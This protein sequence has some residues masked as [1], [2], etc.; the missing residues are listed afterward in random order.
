MDGYTELQ[1]RKFLSSEKYIKLG[2]TR[3]KED[4]MRYY[5]GY[6]TKGKSK[7]NFEVKAKSKKNAYA[8]LKEDNPGWRIVITTSYKHQVKG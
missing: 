8:N 4:K 3:N 5:S 1:L 6:M 2:D 7:K